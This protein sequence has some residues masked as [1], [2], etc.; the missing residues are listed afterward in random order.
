M[1]KVMSAFAAL[2]IATAGAAAT[3]S[4]GAPAAAVAQ[5]TD[6]NGVVIVAVQKDGP[7]AKAGLRRGDIVLKVNAAEV[8]D[9]QALR[10]ALAA[11]KP[12]D[13]AQIRVARGD[14]ELTLKVVL[15][16]AEGRA[17]LGVTP[18]QMQAAVQA[19]P[20]PM[21]GGQ[22]PR[23]QQMDPKQAEEW[24]EQLEERFAAMSKTR[25]TEVSADSPAAK[26]GLKQGDVILAVG[27]AELSAEKSLADVV[28]GLKPGD[29]VTL[30]I[31]RDGKPQE[32]KVS[33]G[34]NPDKKGVA[35]LGIRFAPIMAG[36]MQL[37][38]MQGMPGMPGGGSRMP[39]PDRDGERGNAPFDFELPEGMENA[40]AVGEVV[41]GSPAE[42]AGLMQGDLI[43]AANDKAITSPKDIVELVQASKPGDSVVLSVR[44][45]GEAQPVEITVT[46]GENPD[47][48][49]A[50]YMG[51]ALGSL[52]RME[53]MQPGNEGSM[54]I[55]PGLNLPFQF[56]LPAAPSANQSE[57]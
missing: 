30:K 2:S 57:L 14:S 37:P 49:G 27:E 38:G 46:L 23:G 47:K 54:E 35:F 22:Q 18:F 55:L 19:Q 41:K 6:E 56:E 44:R 31:E 1:V 34:E 16:D 5:G 24:R 13:E 39:M 42:K 28:Q 32:I 11:L 52:I 45:Q 20:A 43:T 53:R 33:L 48:K 12:G 10:D 40:A 25:V 15:G 17:I 29:E 9:A 8:N 3:A 50:A 36:M 21:P 7:A 4:A 26:A 51:V